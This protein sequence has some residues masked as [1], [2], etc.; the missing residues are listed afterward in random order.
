MA[1]NLWHK[2]YVNYGNNFQHANH[3]LT[4]FTKYREEKKIYLINSTRCYC[5]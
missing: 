4:N 1:K 2:W 5:I 3:K